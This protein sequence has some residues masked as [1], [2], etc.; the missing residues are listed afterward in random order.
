MARVR[1]YLGNLPWSATEQDIKKHFDGYNV[2]SVKI[3]ID[4][5][6]QRSKGFAFIDV[7]GTD[8]EELIANFDGTDFCGRTLR[9]SE[10]RQREQRPD[11]N[12]NDRYAKSWK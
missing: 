4:R 12:N 3:I 9:V 2:I 11:T 8:L 6:T 7:D 5:E 10:A 1:I